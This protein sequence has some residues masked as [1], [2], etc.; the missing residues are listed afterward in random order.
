MICWTIGQRLLTIAVFNASSPVIHSRSWSL[1]V[2]RL[3]DDDFYTIHVVVNFNIGRRVVP[4]S[5]DLLSLGVD[6][7]VGRIRVPL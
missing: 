4:G 2:G 6:A 5:N 3:S 7:D 1:V